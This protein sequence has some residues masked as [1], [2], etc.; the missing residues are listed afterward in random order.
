MAFIR[1]GYKD[2]HMA[3]KLAISVNTLRTHLKR[4]FRKLDVHSRAEAISRLDHR[5]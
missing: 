2:T 4:L 5:F 1:L 3:G